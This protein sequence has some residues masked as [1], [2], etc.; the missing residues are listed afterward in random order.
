MPLAS[1]LPPHLPNTARPLAIFAAW[2]S[3]VRGWEGRGGESCYNSFH[4]LL[5][6]L[7][8]NGYKNLLVFAKIIFG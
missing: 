1:S 5:V 2:E 3:L 4:Y 6:G 8:K 7:K